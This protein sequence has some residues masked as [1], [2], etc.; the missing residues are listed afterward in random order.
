MLP[1]DADLGELPD[2]WYCDMNKNDD[3]NNKCSA[4]EKDAE[5][6]GR[7][8]SDQLE[9]LKD[10]PVKCIV[11]D[12]SD[13]AIPQDHKA[14]LIDRDE[15]LKHLLEVT[16]DKQKNSVISKYY[17]HDALLEET[18]DDVFEAVGQEALSK[19]SEKASSTAATL[20]HFPVAEPKPSEKASTTNPTIEA[21]AQAASSCEAT[22]AVI[23]TPPT[24]KRCSTPSA[25][26]ANKKKVSVSPGKL[27]SP[28]TASSRSS[29]QLPNDSKLKR[30]G[31]PPSV[32]QEMT[33]ILMS[34]QGAKQAKKNQDCT[35]RK[36]KAKNLCDELPSGQG[37]SPLDESMVEWHC[38]AS[39]STA[40]REKAHYRMKRNR[41]PPRGVKEA[42]KT[43][44]R[45]PCKVKAKSLREEPSSRQGGSPLD[46][47]MVECHGTAI[48]ST[49]TREKVQDRTS[50]RR[51]EADNTGSLRELG[52]TRQHQESKEGELVDLVSSSS[53]SKAE[54][55]DLM[56]STDLET[57]DESI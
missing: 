55:I 29:S 47:S 22:G 2:K 26:N 32:M 53:L 37:G 50:P 3:A 10:S 46:K 18:E 35:P 52:E 4:S 8:F 16:A 1:F 13:S 38:T 33:H 49:T 48:S 44:D 57:D 45:T 25:V 5:W 42:N 20:L 54:V 6:Y 28:H 36:A 39:S 17:F 14:L 56:D 43:Q 34:R 31:T 12:S 21:V 9:V 11:R 24:Q 51:L 7:H 40:T 19:D 15:I 30:Q 27:K 23:S 41:T